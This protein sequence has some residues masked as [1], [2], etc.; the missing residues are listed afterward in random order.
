MK[1]L[2]RNSCRFIVFFFV[3]YFTILYW[4]LSIS[5]T[6]FL[7]KSHWP[8]PQHLQIQHAK[9]IHYL[10]NGKKNTY[11]GVRSNFWLLWIIDK[12]SNRKKSRFR[13][14]QSFSAFNQTWNSW[15]ICRQIVVDL[16]DC[17][18][19]EPNLFWLWTAAAVK[20]QIHFTS[21]S[22]STCTYKCNGSQRPPRPSSS[23]SAIGRD[24]RQKKVQ[25]KNGVSSQ[26]L[27]RICNKLT[28]CWQRE[29]RADSCWSRGLGV[30]WLQ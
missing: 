19:F 10:Q 18:N 28:P 30:S 15:K 1:H 5:C 9:I 21:K 14:F 16:P 7:F 12:H 25:F 2:I 20:V 17:F 4:R 27:G 26:H 23:D 6:P 13:A 3:R 11:E 29:P 22:T 8:V 24:R